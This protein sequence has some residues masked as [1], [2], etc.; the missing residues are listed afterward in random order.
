M[1]KFDN[2]LS[3]IIT[4]IKDQMQRFAHENKDLH[5]NWLII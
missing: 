3:P 5:K 1:F 2:I 4:S